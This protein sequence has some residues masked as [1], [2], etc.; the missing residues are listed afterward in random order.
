MNTPIG[1]QQVVDAQYLLEQYRQGKQ[2]LDQ[3]ILENERWYRLRCYDNH[4]REPDDPEPASAWL[5]NSLMNKHGDMMD[6]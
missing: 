5:F 4:R 3:R 1:K 2:S 6:A